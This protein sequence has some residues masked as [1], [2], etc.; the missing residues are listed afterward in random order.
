MPTVASPPL[1]YLEGFEESETPDLFHELAWQV[2]RPYL[3]GARLL[4]VG[5]WV[6]AFERL[7]DGRTRVV[8]IDRDAHA[9]R[10]ARRR[11]PAS[12]Q[13]LIG[14]IHQ[15]PLTDAQFDLILLNYVFEHIPASQEV[16]LLTELRRV[17][18]PRGRLVM[19]TPRRH[20]WHALCDVAHWS[21]GHR[22]FH[23]QEI[24]AYL[25]RTGF[26]VESLQVRGGIWAAASIPVF[27]AAKYLARVNLYKIAWV[28]RWLHQE[29]ARPAGFR[30]LFVVARKPA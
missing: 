3:P 4:D 13:F 2:C 16:P 1:R 25:R 12:A 20:W 28:K 26:E 21:V 5:C 19:L 15:L 7:L 17:L 23:E 9:I 27:Y 24:T 14:D 30:D 22:H 10:L 8:A 11:A 18:R 6:G 29:Y